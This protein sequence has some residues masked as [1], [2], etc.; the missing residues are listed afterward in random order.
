MLQN[1]H[2]CPLSISVR[3]NV[4]KLHAGL[5]RHRT[6]CTLCNP[7]QPCVN[8]CILYLM[9]YLC[10]PNMSPGFA[11]QYIVRYA[12]LRLDLSRKML[13]AMT[14]VSMPSDIGQTIVVRMQD[15]GDQN[16]SLMCCS[17]SPRQ[18]LKTFRSRG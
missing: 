9:Q 3:P 1:L 4:Q 17:G 10:H 12:Y 18:A 6:L 7:T 8:V 16:R 11:H 13:N 14:H 5:K 2:V 15:C